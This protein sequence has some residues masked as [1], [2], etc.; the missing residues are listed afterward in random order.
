MHKWTRNPRSY[1]CSASP[2]C[3]SAF[4]WYLSPSPGCCWMSCRVSPPFQAR[5]HPSQGH[6]CCSRVPL[7]S[8]HSGWRFEA[9]AATDEMHGSRLAAYPFSRQRSCASRQAL[10]G[11]A[12]RIQGAEDIEGLG[13]DRHVQLFEHG[14]EER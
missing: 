6:C 14:E 9:L 5:P 13:E 3:S 4:C 8:S 10:L 12:H 7:A 11:H 2:S 1:S